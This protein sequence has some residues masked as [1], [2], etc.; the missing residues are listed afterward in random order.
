M[1][2]TLMPYCEVQVKYLLGYNVPRA[3]QLHKMLYNL[4]TGSK[5]LRWPELAMGLCWIALLLGIKYIAVRQR[6]VLLNQQDAV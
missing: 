1:T 4:I 3:N 6:Y 2:H 5:Q